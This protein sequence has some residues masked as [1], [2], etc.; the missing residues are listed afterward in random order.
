M[1]QCDFK[2]TIGYRFVFLMS[3]CLQYLIELIIVSSTSKIYLVS[4]EVIYVYIKK[5]MISMSRIT[6]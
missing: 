3:N 2:L 5:N 6:L 4:L 1:M